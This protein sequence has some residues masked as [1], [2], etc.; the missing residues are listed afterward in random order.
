MIQSNYFTDNDDLQLQFKNIIDWESIV[1]EGEQNFHD[2][3][4]FDKTKDDRYSM[5]PRTTAEAV[6]YYASVLDSLGEMMGHE[7]A[8]RGAEMD[9]I[10][11]KYDNGKV[12]Y[13]EAQDYLYTKLREA[14]L[15]PAA[16]GRK[17]GGLALPAVAQVIL[18]EIAS[19]ADAAF[20]LAY[21]N[22]NVAEVVARYGS[23]E[24]VDEWIPKF[25]SAEIS[26]AM[27]L[28]E[29]NYGSD[30]PN[31]QT[32]A[33]KG[34]DGVWR[35]TGTKRFITHAAGYKDSPCVILTLARTGGP[36]S[37]ARGLSF[38]MVHSKDVHIAGIE[39]KMGLHC[40]PTCEVVY[41]NAP[42]ILIGEEGLGLVRY[43]MGMMNSARLTIAAQSLGIAQAAQMEA[44]KYA[45]ERIQF[46]KPI[47]EIPAVKKMLDRMEVEIAAMRC[48]AL[49]AG[50]CVDMYMWRTEHLLKEEKKS[51]K[52]A[53]N[54]EQVSKWSKLADLFTPL[55]KYYTSEKCVQIAYDALQIHGGAGYTEE[56][57]VARIY[58]DSR[59][60][61]IYEGTTQLQI[62]AAI[63]GVAAGMAPAG[64]LREYINAE[65]ATFTPSARLK[66]T[67]TEFEKVVNEYRA[68]EKGDIK[69]R[70]AFE[71]VES[72]ARFILGMLLERSAAKLSGEEKSK[73]L[74]LCDQL[75]EESLAVLAANLTKLQLARESA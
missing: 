18:L 16:F 28:T 50:R 4:L 73:R 58:R 60:T 7:V 12:I 39:K 68:M 74:A 75:H 19:R 37:G 8:P 10:G 20:A 49:E 43:S 65:M 30:L 24:M 9:R 1:K 21:G 54:D 47:Q 64:H 38:F 72:G 32:K 55:S 14:G 36:K 66:R 42:A 52:E 31:V 6:E 17:H 15:M 25:A 70:Y 44:K 46:G 11:L 57:D 40:S 53:R 2:A 23:E 48:L 29:P 35:V 56:Y 51:E 13:P 63:G 22:V 62:V 5:A 67:F 41:E 71:T 61:T 69:A 33:V 26:C 27:A 34:E 59:I 3:K 45:S